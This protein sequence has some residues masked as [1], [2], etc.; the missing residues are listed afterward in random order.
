[1]GRARC[2]ASAW[3]YLQVIENKGNNVLLTMAWRIL[4]SHSDR[5]RCLVLQNTFPTTVWNDQSHDWQ[6]SLGEGCDPPRFMSWRL[7]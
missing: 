2:C 3:E 6:A 5:V 1:M 4:F 7:T